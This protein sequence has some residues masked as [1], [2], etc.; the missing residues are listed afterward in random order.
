MAICT[1]LTESEIKNY[2]TV[3]DKELNELFQE[4]RRDFE[5]EFFISEME[6]ITRRWFK[7]PVHETFYTLY[8]ATGLPEVQVINFY[9]DGASSINTGVKKELVM[10]LFYGML[11]GADYVKKGLLI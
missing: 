8:K 3:K 11:N 5:N 9:V 6:V 2:T 7:K 1:W 10:A 4:V